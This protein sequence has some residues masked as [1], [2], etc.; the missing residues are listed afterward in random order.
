VGT[1]DLHTSQKTGLGLVSVIIIEGDEEEEEP[2]SSGQLCIVLPLG[3]NKAAFP[4]FSQGRMPGLL[5]YSFFFV[6]AFRLYFFV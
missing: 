6:F 3:E 1:S 2:V 5:I 4:Q